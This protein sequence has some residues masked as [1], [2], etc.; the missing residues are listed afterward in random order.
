MTMRDFVKE[1]Y[2]EPIGDLDPALKKLGSIPKVLLK[3]QRK[4]TRSLLEIPLLF[5]EKSR[6]I[7]ATWGV[8]AHAV[9]LS[10]ASKK[11]G[12]MD[13]LYI[14][15]NQDMAREFIDACAMWARAFMGFTGAAGEELFDD[16]TIDG[17]THQIKAFRIDFVT[18][19]IQALTSRPRSLRGRQGFVI[20]DEAAY[21]DAL[22]EMMKAAMAL[23]IWGGQVLVLST[24]NGM[25]NAFNQ[26]IVAA[27][28]GDYGKA[29]VLTIPFREA[30][31]DGL[32]KRKCLISGEEWSQ[33]KEDEWVAGIYAFYGEHAAEELD[34]IPARGSGNYFDRTTIEAAMS[35]GG[36][37]IQLHCPIDFL[38]WDAAR[39]EK[40]ITDWW[41]DSVDT[42]IAAAAFAPTRACFFGNDFARSGD[43]SIIVAG[44]RRQDGVLAVPIVIEMR[45]VP[46]AE[47]FWIHK[48]LI[49]SLPAFG[50]GVMDAR[51]NGQQL[52]EDLRR[53]YGPELIESAMASARFYLETFP[54][55]KDMISERTIAL[56]LDENHVLDLRAVKLNNG[57]P[58]IPER[59]AVK[60]EDGKV[61]GFRHG[62]Y[63]IA[64]N[65]LVR[66]ARKA[67]DVGFSFQSSGNKLGPKDV[68]GRSKVDMATGFGRVRRRRL[69]EQ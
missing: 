40:Y 67:D 3:Y 7:G 47:Q 32:Y 38:E 44:Q 18:F 23:L 11:A 58:M 8:A 57:I 13:T 1:P 19:K 2:V 56:I 48:K 12:G 54:R 30:V 24:H 29:A 49:E 33:E 17:K 5:L 66:A 59:K 52:S 20:F 42:V 25:D 45:N 46:F 15:Y 53:L 4:I 37:V 35:L 36:D 43:L 64:L 28:R 61:K 51:G 10:A 39:Q 22:D 60:G 62:D 16:I 34:V 65:N 55:T 68:R 14:G 26:A 21:H 6:R 31:A 41:R 63:A 69:M 50:G 9:L 27:R